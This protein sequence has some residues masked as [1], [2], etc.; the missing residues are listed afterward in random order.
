MKITQK[1]YE[2]ILEKLEATRLETGGI[3]G[4]K[5]G[6]VCAFFLDNKGQGKMG[7]YRPNVALLNQV[8]ERWAEEDVAFVGLVH[9]HINGLGILSPS[10][11][12]YARLILSANE[13]EYVYFPVV[14]EGKEGKK[15]MR[16]YRISESEIIEE[17]NE[18]FLL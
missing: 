14:V 17:D 10:D 4:E 15:L 8:I 5:D 3:L 18:I 1:T 9:T 7:E 16:S 6:T 13:L 11:I 12:E 2:E